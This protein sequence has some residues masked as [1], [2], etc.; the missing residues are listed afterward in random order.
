[1]YTGINTLRSFGGLWTCAEVPGVLFGAIWIAAVGTEDDMEDL[2]FSAMPG[3]IEQG[4]RPN[5]PRD[6]VRAEL[7]LW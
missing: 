1:L 6:R 5:L 2:K 3:R 4:A 7:A